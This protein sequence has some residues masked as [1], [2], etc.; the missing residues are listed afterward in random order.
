MSYLVDTNAL[1]ELRRRTPDRNVVA[2]F[3]ERPAS[4]L[5]VSVLTLA[6]IRRG[7][8]QLADEKRRAALADWLE[9]DLRAFFTGRI[10]PVDTAV[11][12]RW[13]RLL[14][15]ATRPV[16]AVDSLIA[17]TAIAHDLVL[18]TRNVRDFEALPV[19][20]LDP[21][22]GALRA[23]EPTRHWETGTA[24]DV[25]GE[26]KVSASSALE[27][28]NEVRSL[29][30]KYEPLT[31]FL[32]SQATHL[33]EV[34]ISLAKLQEIL[35]APLPESAWTHG[36]WWGNQKNATTRPQVRAWMAAGFAVAGV[37]QGRDGGWVR[38]RR[39]P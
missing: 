10:L 6:E 31:R 15:R 16:P 29:S 20:V 5:Y 18:V 12:D 3:A 4:T 1:S 30:G 34:T 25:R 32:R 23:Q 24:S 7:I 19:R 35:A 38:F 39:V 26:T 2:W 17:A 28:R 33:R 37:N 13:G 9:V 8:E 21:W 11:A 27:N 36:P 14:A 22:A